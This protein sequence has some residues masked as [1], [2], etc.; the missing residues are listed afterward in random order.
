MFSRAES[1]REYSFIV[2]RG[3]TGPGEEM[4]GGF[5]D[6]HIRTDFSNDIAGG[7]YGNAWEVRGKLDQIVV[8]IGEFC[9]G[10]VQVVNDSVKIMR[11][12]AAEFHFEGLVIGNLITNDGDDNNMEMFFKDIENGNP[13]FTSGF[14]AD[15]RTVMFKEPVTADIE[16]RIESGEPLF[17]VSGNAFEVSSG[18]TDSDKFLWESIPAQLW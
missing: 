16:V 6:R 15:L 17:P 4:L 11:M 9:N 3:K 1:F 7:V 12:V 5:E 18:D 8:R 2:L 13:V 10:I 14:H